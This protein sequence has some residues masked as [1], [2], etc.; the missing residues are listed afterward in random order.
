MFISV[1]I[2]TLRPG[3]TY[4]DFLEAWY[5][6]K[7]FEGFGFDG[8]GP[9]VARSLENE[10]ELLAFGLIDLEDPK[11]LM[12]GIERVADAE[13]ARRGKIDEVIQSTQVR[14][15]YEV[16]DEFDFSS[17]EAVEAGRP[18]R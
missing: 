6:E 10:R 18:R 17:R 8:R 13:A 11:E 4:D 12:A 9:L 16:R 14:G 7:G 1:L 5:P 15:I 3:K 2:R